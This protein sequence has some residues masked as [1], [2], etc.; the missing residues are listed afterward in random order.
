MTKVNSIPTFFVYY[1][2]K[3]HFIRMDENGT[4]T[5]EFYDGEVIVDIMK[6]GVFDQQLSDE[7]RP[8]FLEFFRSRLMDNLSAR[9]IYSFEDPV[10]VAMAHTLEEAK[11]ID[12]LGAYDAWMGRDGI[13]SDG[14]KEAA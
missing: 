11:A 3:V 8:H 1:T 7:A 6:E 2:P 9:Y 12:A 10:I 13:P 5:E 14:K 4:E